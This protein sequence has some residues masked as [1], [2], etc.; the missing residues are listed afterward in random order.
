MK[1][2]FAGTPTFATAALLSLLN[3]KHEIVLVLTQ[4]DRPAGR[5]MQPKESAIKKIAQQY[6]L[7]LA[8]PEIGKSNTV[9]IS[10]IAYTCKTY[11]NNYNAYSDAP[12]Y[13][14]SIAY[15]PPI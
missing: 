6:Q 8:Q 9:S 2:I 1:L 4:P 5:S 13:N 14:F 7:K 15:I 11:N 10:H 3:T 12:F